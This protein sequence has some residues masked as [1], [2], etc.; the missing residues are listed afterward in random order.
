MSSG[1]VTASLATTRTGFRSRVRRTTARRG[2]TWAL[3]GALVLGLA[4]PAL[5][6]DPDPCPSDGTA[7]PTL[8]PIEPTATPTPTPT[9]DGS[10]PDTTTPTDAAT[11]PTDPATTPTDPT[12]TSPTGSTGGATTDPAGTPTGVAP[13]GTSTPTGSVSGTS[14]STPSPV[15]VAPAAAAPQPA[16]PVAAGTTPVST[17]VALSPSRSFG[18]PV[19]AP[20]TSVAVSTLGWSNPAVGRLT[21]GFGMRVH[22]I[23]GIASLHAGQDIAARCGAPVHAAAGGVV[24]WVGGAFQGRT[25]NQVVIANGNGIVTRYGHLLSGSILVTY[26]Q[27]VQAGQQIAAVGGDAGIDPSGAGLSTG[28]HLHFEVNE[29]DGMTPVNPNAFLDARGVRLGVDMPFVFT[30]PAAPV[31]PTLATSAADLDRIKAIV[32]ARKPA[33]AIRPLG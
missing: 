6:E 24:A 27:V 23:F 18:F 11:T 25:G 13:S 30:A 3:T 15:P 8:C 28:C 21:S 12:T 22:P 10:T 33:S 16:A 2:A 4:G 26:G 20:P 5:A 17:A 14:T 31:S 29:N 9:I 1:R 7:D 19:L 32:T